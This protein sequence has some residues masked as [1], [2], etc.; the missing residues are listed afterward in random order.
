MP[1]VHL[2]DEAFAQILAGFDDPAAL[3]H[4]QACSL[5]RRQLESVSASLKS[6]NDLGMLWATQQSQHLLV[7]A[8]RMSRWFARPG[9]LVPATLAGLCALLLGVNSTRVDRHQEAVSPSTRAQS[10]IAEDNRLMAA[11]HQ[12]LSVPVVLQVPVSDL[13]E[14]SS[15]GRQ[16]PAASTVE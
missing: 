6:M 15:Q 7:P 14:H 10:K 3:H 13:R 9:W 16:S 1:D 5:C 12:E 11:I 8:P 4:L 2:T